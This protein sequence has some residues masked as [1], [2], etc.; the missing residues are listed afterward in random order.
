MTAITEA[1]RV[2]AVRGAALGLITASLIEFVVGMG[3]NLF[4]TITRDHPGAHGNSGYFVRS[5]NSVVWGLSH[6]GLL[7]FHIGIGFVL[8]LGSIR[9][10]VATF[11]AP[12]RGIRLASLVG[13]LAVAGAG[14]NGASFLDFDDDFSSMLMTVLFAIAVFC[15]ALVLYNCRPHDIPAPTTRLP[16]AN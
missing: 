1:S 2:R 16:E 3:L 14:F 9:L 11:R 12:G 6:F 15:F 7:P 10:A 13:L 8:F 4:I 5:L